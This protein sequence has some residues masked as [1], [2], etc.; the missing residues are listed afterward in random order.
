M[1]VSQ[2][3]AI[4]W[5]HREKLIASHTDHSHIAKLKRGENGPYADIKAA[6]NQAM[7]SVGNLYSESDAHHNMTTMSQAYESHKPRVDAK[8]PSYVVEMGKRSDDEPRDDPANLGPHQSAPLR[9]RSRSP[10]SR[11]SQPELEHHF[12]QRN[13]EKLDTTKRTHR[14]QGSSASYSYMDHNVSRCQSSL[15]ENVPLP[16]SSSISL[17]GVTAS[18]EIEHEV[19]SRDNQYNA[20]ES[21]TTGTK[22]ASYDSHLKN[23][24]KR[25]DIQGT[26]DLLATL[27]EVNCNDE[28]N[29]TPLHG[30]AYYRSEPL[31]KLLLE[32]GAHPRAQTKMG[33]TT[34]HLIA[35]PENTLT[36]LRESLIDLLLQHPPP[37]DEP[38]LEGWTPL[39]GA[40]SI[41]EHLLATKLISRGAR[42]RLTDKEG[43]TAL[44]YAAQNAEGLEMITL[45]IKEGALVEAKDNENWT[46][47]HRAAY[48]CNLHAI[49]T[50]LAHGANPFAKAQTFPP[51]GVLPRGVIER[52]ES[53]TKEQKQE[54]RKTFKEAEKEW[55]R[56][57]KKY[58]KFHWSS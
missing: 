38:A 21:M 28:F 22:S 4:Q 2:D 29:R 40:A 14:L 16:Q 56:S 13:D 51:G 19:N 9:S 39:M 55:K 31:V 30:A 1:M 58:P 57:G 36:P 17:G 6:I 52:S 27:Y 35:R 18:C 8:K 12:D 46:P 54:V 5:Y 50:L 48:F 23:A 53:T 45:L 34:L 44:H 20:S 37:L 26:K 43:N 33:Q 49:K 24:I 32:L 47:L 42:T 41:G 3:S 7:L 25:G 10:A 11:R 15:E